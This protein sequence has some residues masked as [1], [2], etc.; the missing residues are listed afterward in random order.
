MCVKSWKV[1]NVDSKAS[2]SLGVAYF[3]AGNAAC[4]ATLHSGGTLDLRQVPAQNLSELASVVIAGA[5]KPDLTIHSISILRPILGHDRSLTSG[6]ILGG[7]SKL[8]RI[9]GMS[10]WR[11]E[12]RK[13]LAVSSLPSVFETASK[14]TRH[15]LDRVDFQTRSDYDQEIQMLL[16][17]F[18]LGEEVGREVFA[19]HDNVGL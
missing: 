10:R 8:M 19:E 1:R 12:R 3:V 11:T 7:W 17:L 5:L 14:L 6:L 13:W 2:M 16:V 4:G 9:C 18:Q 15:I